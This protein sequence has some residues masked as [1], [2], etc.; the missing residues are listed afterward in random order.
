MAED[1][2]PVAAPA[3]NKPQK[4]DEAAFKE[5]VGKLEKEHT[6]VKSQLVRPI[7]LFLLLL[8]VLFFLLLLFCL[9]TCILECYVACC[10]CYTR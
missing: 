2:A 5:K 3:A 1:A 9:A 7:V 8:L 10:C 6:Q 4:P